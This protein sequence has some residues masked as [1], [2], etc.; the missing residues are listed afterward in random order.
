MATMKDFAVKYAS[1]LFENPNETV[2]QEIIKEIKSLTKDG[3]PLLESDVNKLTALIQTEL[4][5]KYKEWKSSNE[6][7]LILEKSYHYT[8]ASTDISEFND[9]VNMIVKGT[10][11]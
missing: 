11:K 4:Q 2:V 10:R 9:L 3:K 5:T 7:S 6:D 1:R 8:T